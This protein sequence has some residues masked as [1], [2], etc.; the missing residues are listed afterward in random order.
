MTTTRSLPFLLIVLALAGCGDFEWFP[1]TETN[2]GSLG[3]VADAERNAPVVSKAFTITGGSAAI[4]IANGE[5]SID[6]AP[7]TSASGNVQ[8]G[9]S[10]T[11]RH[12]TSNAYSSS[13]TTVLTI[14]NESIPF[15]S[16]TMSKPP[17]FVNSSTA[18]DFTFAPKLDVEPN[19]VIV[20]DSRTITGNTS[21]APISITDG[22]YST[23]GTDFTSSA[24]TINAG[25][26]LHVRHTSPTTYQTIKTTRLTVGGV[27]TNFSSMTKA[28]PFVNYSTVSPVNADPTNVISVAQPLAATKDFTTSTHVSFSIR[29]FLN[30]SSN[31]QK[32]IGLTIAG[33]DAQNRRIYYGTI[34]AAVPA[35]A[36]P[37]TSTHSF[38][39]ALTIAQYNSITQWLVTKIII[40][41]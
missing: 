33:A 37:S 41:Q 38:G 3:T 19:T 8:T 23:N 22:E 35:N 12:I 17:V 24:G 4:S 32:N 34:D 40:Y 28:A 10:V 1:D 21:P 5:Y 20:S 11:V 27:R 39:A 18:T 15:T 14:A 16:V 31:E 13:M 26:S 7:Y 36:N 30:N 29:Y 6:G 25:Q 2:Q 9:Q